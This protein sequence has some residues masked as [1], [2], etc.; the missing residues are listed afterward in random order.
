VAMQMLERLGIAELSERPYTEISGGERQLALIA[1]ALAQGARIL[2]MDEPVSGLD[3]GNQLRFLA[4][5]QDLAADG[6]A[7]VKA[8]HHPE[9]TLLASTRVALLCDG[10][11]LLDGPPAEVITPDTIQRIYGVEVCAIAGANGDTVAFR[12][13]LRGVT[14]VPLPL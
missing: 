14:G 1:R 4:L 13:T 5:L 8:T 11:I 12:P 7:V 3:Y 9:Q 6:Y 2:V 10:A